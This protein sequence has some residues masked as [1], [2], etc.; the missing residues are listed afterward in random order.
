MSLKGEK[1]VQDR[2]EG[3]AFPEWPELRPVKIDDLLVELQGA[4]ISM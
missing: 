3:M 2:E 1:S 4:R